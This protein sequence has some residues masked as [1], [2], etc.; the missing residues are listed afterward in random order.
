MRR[1]RHKQMHMLSSY[2]TFY[3]LNFQLAAY[4]SH[5]L[6]KSQGNL[7]TQQLLPVLRDPNQMVLDVESGMGGT[8]VMFHN[9][10]LLK[11]SP[12]G[13]GFNIP[14]RDY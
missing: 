3:Y 7:A 14:K 2:V 13:E 10:F 1:T 12:E 8:S 4:I 9:P 6:S 5:D 11:L